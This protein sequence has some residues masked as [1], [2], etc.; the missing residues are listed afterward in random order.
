MNLSTRFKPRHSARIVALTALVFF[1]GIRTHAQTIVLGTASN[2]TVIGGASITNTGLTV[3]SGASGGIAGTGTI[4]GFPPGI[5]TGGSIHVNDAAAIQA[6]A[7]ATT[8]YNQLVAL[9]FT[10]D[11]TGQNLA[12]LNLQPGVFK[13]NDAAAFTSGV[14]TLDGMNQANPLFV[15]QIGSTL[16]SSGTVSFNFINGATANNLWFQVGSSATLGSG[17]SFAGTIIASAS[18]TLDTGASLNGRVF[19]LTGTVTLNANQITAPSAIPEPSTYAAI[20]A[21]LALMFAAGRRAH[22]AKRRAA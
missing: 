1:T 4:T 9:T 7:D 20:V 15:F 17:A 6:K 18:D 8:A 3:I 12:G 11:L 2:F 13:Y 10:S 5:V 19:A 21:G 16:T 14:L 22:A